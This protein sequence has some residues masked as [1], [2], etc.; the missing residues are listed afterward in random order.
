MAVSINYAI[1]ALRELVTTINDSAIQL[2]GAA[3]QT[4]GGAAH[5]AKASSAQSRQISSARESMAEMATSIEGVSGNSERCS[6]VAR[7]SVDVSHKGGDAV[8][9]TIDGMNAIRETIQETSKRINR[10]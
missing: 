6:D 10:P 4:Q 9:R 2:D 7:H 8:R 5:M 3:K 1:E